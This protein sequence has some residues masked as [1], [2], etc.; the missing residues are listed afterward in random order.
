[1]TEGNIPGSDRK[2]QLLP[3]LLPDMLNTYQGEIKLFELSQDTNGKEL[4]VRKK[5]DT[6]QWPPLQWLYCNAFKTKCF[7]SPVDLCI[8]IKPPSLL[9][10]DYPRKYMSIIK[11]L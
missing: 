6:L 8:Q 9:M 10:M 4:K 2:K 7:A 5:Q 1:M 11:G 3:Y